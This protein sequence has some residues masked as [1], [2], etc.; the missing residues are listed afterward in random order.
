MTRYRAV[1]A[2]DGSQYF[3][4]QRQG[5]AVSV[6]G[7]VEAAIARITGQAVNVVGAGRTDTGVHAVGQV[8][9]FDVEWR[10]EDADLLRALNAVLPDDIALQALAADAGFHPR[11]NVQFRRYVY[12]VLHARQRQPLWRGRAWW[13]PRKLDIALMQQGAALLV[14]EHDFATFGTPPK[15]DNTVRRL[16]KSEWAAQASA[17]GVFLTYTIEGTAFLHHMVRRIVGMLADVGQGHWSLRAFE[18]AFRAADLTQAGTVAP[19]QGLVLQA[20]YYN[21]HNEDSLG[22]SSLAP[23]ESENNFVNE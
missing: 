15:G 14:G 16:F 3:G 13:I 11:R 9:A 17:E 7:T 23:A 1:L 5:D 22:S 2:Y 20:V 19:P 12:T 21:P 8:I 4:F 10:H 18:D 6:Q